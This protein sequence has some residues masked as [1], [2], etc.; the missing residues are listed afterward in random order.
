MAIHGE[1]RSRATIYDVAEAAGV[2]SATVSRVFSGGNSVAAATRDRVLAV[3]DSLGFRLNPLARNLSR[4]TSDVVAVMLPDVRHP[5]FS[6]LLRG[7]QWA[8][9]RQGYI[10]LVFNTG[11][12]PDLERRYLDGL[13]SRQVEYVLAV[14][15]VLDRAQVEGYVSAGLKFI[16]LDRPLKHSKTMLL[17][18]DNHDGARLATGHL[19]GLG[20]RRIA[21]IAGPAG[22]APSHDRHR[23]Y[24]AALAEAGI[25]AD[26]SLVVQSEFSEQGGSRALEELDRRGVDYTAVFAADDLIAIGIL[27]AAQAGGRR[28]PKDLSV[29]GFDDVLP[30][31][32]IVPAL[33]TVR[34]DAIGLSERAVQ[35]IVSPEGR[36]P[37]HTFVLPVSLVIR[38]STGMPPKSSAASRRR[39][40]GATD[41]RH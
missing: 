4:G 2:S 27:S 29:V 22:V 19:L 7:L 40:R 1:G 34:Q 6:E 13:L 38:G 18:S 15:L 8:A 12:D 17:Q 33:T 21:H 30:A 26:E 35:A 16:A 37:R 14:G 39:N 10:T 31:R 20:H 32:F 5:F 11:G 36:D 28:V 3:A 24:L 23:G 25:A 41:R 9:F